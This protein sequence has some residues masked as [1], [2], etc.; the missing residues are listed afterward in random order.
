MDL[1]ESLPPIGLA[2]PAGKILVV[3]DEPV[4]IEVV[5]QGLQ[6]IG[7]QVERAGGGTQALTRLEAGGY[8]IV[9][10]DVRMPGMGGLE[11]FRA[12][13]RRYP[14]LEDRVI[15]MTGETIGEQVNQALAETGL[16]ILVKPFGVGR[17]HRAIQ[18]LLNPAP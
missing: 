10:S 13:Q 9:L 4:V 1:Y 7:Y 11:L 18:A 3:D 5:A 15:F 12:I 14:A 2:L 17:V 8:D 16:P 6:R